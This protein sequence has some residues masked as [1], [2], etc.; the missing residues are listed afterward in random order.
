MKTL[1]SLILLLALVSCTA[2]DVP[3]FQKPTRINWSTFKVPPVGTPLTLRAFNIIGPREFE[4]VD[5]VGKWDDGKP[6]TL[7]FPI[8]RTL[9]QVVRIE[10]HFR[11]DVL[12]ARN[13]RPPTTMTGGE[14]VGYRK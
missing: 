12:A 2:V 11:G 4:T 13:F 6:Y 9:N 1:L 10:I 8:T 3:G 5:F 7:S 14:T